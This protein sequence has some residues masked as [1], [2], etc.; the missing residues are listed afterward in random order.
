MK[1]SRLL[2][3]FLLLAAAASA[4]T[5]TWND[6]DANN[7]W[8]T[9]DANWASAA[10]FVTAD[11]AVF[12]GTGEAVTVL[13]GGV[14]PASTAVSAGS[15]TFS[16]GTISGTLAKSGAG[17]LTLN[18]A[19][20]FSGV[21][22]TSGPA[23]GGTTAGAINVGNA[24][25][26]GSGN[27]VLNN[28]T[29]ITALYVNGNHNLANNI[30]LSSTASLTTSFSGLNGATATL[31]GLISGGTASSVFWV[32]M[33]AGGSNGVLKLSNTGNTFRSTM[34]FNRGVLAINGDGCLGNSA[35]LIR[36][37]QTSNNGGL[38]FDANNI[39]VQH[40]IEWVSRCDFNIN[41]F[42]ATISA[43][44]SGAGNDEANR[45]NIKGGTITSGTSTGS[46]RLS[47]TN[48]MA[49]PLTVAANTKLI[50]ASPTAL[51]SATGTTRVTAG[52]TLAFDSVG[53]YSNLE[54]LTLN[55]TGVQV[56]SVGVGA[57]QNLSGSNSFAGAIALGSASS[58]GVTSGSLSLSGVISGAFPLTKT[59]GTL[60]LSGANTFSGGLNL[61]SGTLSASSASALGTG[62]VTL[63]NAT[64]LNASGASALSLPGGLTVSSTAS[65]GFNGTSCPLTIGGTTTLSGAAG[66]VTL[67][68][69]GAAPAVGT[70]PLITYSGSLGGTGFPAF[71]LG[72]LP[73]RV[74]AN[75][76]NNTGSSS[77]D[78]N[79]T[80]VDFPVWSGAQDSEWSTNTISGSKNWVLNSN[81]ATATDY[82]AGDTVLFND[83]ATGTTIDI[84]NGNVAP[85]AVT[86]DNSTK[87]FTLTG[88]NGIADGAA[89]LGLTKSGSGS[90]TLSNTN[91][92][93]GAVVL[94]GG[95]VIIPS[96]ANGG[97][98]SPLGSG[99]AVNF[100]GGQLS[101][102]G[103]SASTNRGIS[104]GASGG[105]LEVTNASSTLSLASTIS[106]SGTLTL[107]G[108]GKTSFSGTST[109]AGA[110]SI[111]SGAFLEL[112]TGAV[113]GSTPLA[114]N[115][116]ISVNRSDAYTLSNAISG[117]GILVKQNTNTLTL[118]GSNSYSGGSNLN[119]GALTLNT[120][121]ALGTGALT[122]G[123]AATNGTGGGVATVLV[124]NTAATTLAN[125]LVMP[126][127][128]G[129]FT[130]MKTTA[131][132]TTGT[133]LNLTGVISGGGPT[134][135]L[136]LNSGTGGDSTTS[137]RLAGSNTL[138]GS[139]ELYRGAVVITN[140]NSLGNAKLLLNANNNGTLGDVRF[141]NPVTLANEIVL[142]N[143]SNP[144]PINTNGNTVVLNGAVTSTGTAGLVKIGAGTLVFGAN[145]PY[146]VAT[147][148]SAGT[149]QVG[150]GGTTGSFG[151]GAV[152]NNGTLAFNRST[153]LSVPN[154]ISGTGAIVQS[155]SGTTTLS[156]AI[157][158]A[159]SYT[160]D[161]GGLTINGS[162][163][164]AATLAVNGGQF[165]FGTGSNPIGT[166]AVDSLTQTGG[167]LSLEVDGSSSDLLQVTNA[168]NL[169]SGGIV[170]NVLNAPDTG[171]AYTLINYG[172][173]TGTPSLTV[174]GLSGSRLTASLDP[175]TGTASAIT[176]TFSGSVADLVWSGASDNTWD[177][178]TTQNWV[179]A[180]NPDTFHILDNVLF[181]DSPTSGNTSPILNFT[182]VAG[183]VTF[184]NTTKTYTITGSGGIGGS[185]NVSI[186]GGGTTIFATNNSYTGI[187]DISN[188]ST[189]KIGNGGAVGTL[190]NGGLAQ[191]DGTLAFDRSDDITVANV[192]TGLGT[193]SQLGAGSLIL[194]GN[195][196]Y[197][198]TNISAG[199][200]QIGAG[201]T[202]GR[203]GVDEVTNNGSLVYNRSDAQTL[204]NVISGSGS[205][206]KL[207]AG[208]LTLSGNSSYSGGTTLT[209]GSLIGGGSNAFGTGPVTIATGTLVRF[210]IDDGSTATFPNNFILPAVGSTQFSVL[211]PASPTTVRLTGV[212][213]GGASGQTYNLCDT[214]AT[215][216]HNNVII[217]DNASNSFTGTILMNRGTLAFTSDAAL[218]NPA[219]RVRIDTWNANGPFRFD[220]D[221]L[222]LNAAR[223]IELVTNGVIL[224]IN[225]QAFT[226]T[227]AGQVTGAG[228]LTKQGTGTLV[229][230]NA[231]NNYAGTT[232]INAG[233]LRVN[234]TLTSSTSAVTVTATGTLSGTGTI[235]RPVTVTGTVAPGDSAGTLSIGAAT[236]LDGTLAT[237]VD[238][239]VSDK[240]V[241]TGNLTLGA[242]S[243]VT[244]SLLSGG[245]TQPS[246]VIA[247][248]TGTLSGTFA[249]VPSGYAVTYT[250]TQAI[251]TQVAGF[252]SWATAKGLDGT[253]G[254]EDGP[255][256]DPDQD[257]IANLLE[258]ML[259]GNPLGNS[260]AILPTVAKDATN[261]TLTF[262]RRD[263]SET[264]T[265]QFVE[266]GSTLG[267]W[268]P[269]AIPSAA[270]T[271]VVTAGGK[272]VSFTLTENSTDPD[273]IVVEIP[274]G[275]D[276]TLFARIKA[277]K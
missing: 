179:N 213:S 254:K 238:G 270:G 30:Q 118:S 92:F 141:E 160:V 45:N 134:S 79:V 229:L 244:V 189:L 204:S 236:N 146:S 56:S 58:I 129:T 22:I 14:A 102:T 55:G 186:N 11:A 154:A 198:A 49:A 234:G 75:L 256:D 103:A 120:S 253:A 227:I 190:G 165:A 108:P 195:N 115:G 249:T 214:L 135:V 200:L 16:G 106:G 105:G 218:G 257:G 124:N 121:D 137:Y 268:T 48:T 206:T 170:L 193:V 152:T 180:G 181:D 116:T 66:S 37:D 4:K 140:D 57:L 188:G 202:A 230:T 76:V 235:N 157:A 151:A 136:R 54:P 126:S 207:G 123:S 271:T 91:S 112:A 167:S 263:D 163:P 133:E 147:T 73:N 142:A 68:L 267:G 208:A 194:T 8:N 77:V 26:L 47:G 19:N 184:A 117:T 71:A 24:S 122:I 80:G 72:A 38:R 21:T 246:Y 34:Y 192:L 144:D 64:T 245:F 260:S 153:A 95:T 221:N 125:N 225:T 131:S 203:I 87:N 226:G 69:F 15:Y 93:T 130:L 114:N 110:V 172:S 201:G 205:L 187:T 224:P 174:N 5:I 63:A 210:K 23:N 161:N 216:N 44:I 248:C 83:F 78:L 143:S 258:Y 28:T 42:D 2:L 240:L 269:V 67:N 9:T 6:A 127:A 74:L 149:L 1:S 29:S 33:S 36:F 99:T 107:N 7:N 53:I 65:V 88:T 196:S 113:L 52:G 168:Y 266:F 264:D 231:A 101:Y 159:S 84:S 128:A 89:S 199:T 62:L 255:S 232:T 20:S 31:S 197:G 46:L 233:T 173:L 50:A 176:V 94:N 247:E 212:I 239:A 155:G 265:T 273:Q 182:A 51:G 18:S 217:L 220:A 261:L 138:S 40:N 274:V 241:V 250:S 211:S 35:N 164:A 27:V 61:N 111:S 276:T 169:S 12:S 60:S 17:S 100:N 219:N 25:A 275:T 215:G 70:Y 243:A 109:L 13:A 132:Q 251:L 145:N 43:N 242:G 97:T 166:L 162:S 104:L 82:L 158:A 119:G 3:S 148:I 156:G 209:T 41:N 237:E 86:F 183:S 150:N 191:I 171:S 178:V 252:T 85:A 272:S 81:N 39:N 90:L 277:T 259:D 59:G 262:S 222:T 98:S 228:A 10:T 185:S 223:T 175:G 32:N 96:I 139:I 177:L